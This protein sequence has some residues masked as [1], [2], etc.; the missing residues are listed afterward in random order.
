M[1]GLCSQRF[2]M[3]PVKFHSFWSALINQRTAVETHGK[4]QARPFHVA[5]GFPQLLALDPTML[6]D[7]SSLRVATSAP[8]TSCCPDPAQSVSFKSLFESHSV[9][10]G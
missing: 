1:R 10:S 4:G 8:V 6:R 2:L 5:N 3:N 7:D 9:H